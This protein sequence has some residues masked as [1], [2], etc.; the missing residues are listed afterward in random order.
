MN[1]RPWSQV[2][3]EHLDV[4][5]QLAAAGPL[6]DEMAALLI[7]CI[8]GGGR[9]YL[10]G[11]GGS[12][13]DAEHIATEL[14]GRFKLDRRALPAIAL[15]ANTSTMTAIGNDL[16]YDR[17]FARQLEGLI[18]GGDVAWAISTSGN[19]PNVLAAIEVARSADARVIGFSGR[20]GG[21]M[22]DACDLLLRVPHDKS[23]RIQEGHELAYHYLCE[24]IEASFAGP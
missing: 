11:N 23:D 13:A 20:G 19:S 3:A 16:G 22:A 21:A 8:R 12:A 1:P 18:T 10:F 14:L 5:G 2:H 17:V 24:R 4:I 6:L 7:D 15:S 9:I